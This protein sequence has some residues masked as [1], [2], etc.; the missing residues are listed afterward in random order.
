MPPADHHKI[1]FQPISIG[2]KT[3]RNR[4]YNV[5]HGTA[6][7]VLRPATW[8]SYRGVRAEGGWAAVSTEFS[9]V[10]PS[11]DEFP[12]HSSDIWDEEDARRHR[13]MVESVHAHGALAGIELHHGG[14]H[15]MRRIS[16]EPALSP[17]GLAS[18]LAPPAGPP[19]T[20]KAMTRDDIERIEEA[21]VKAAVRARD[22]GY[23]IVDVLAGY[24]YLF[25]Q[26]LSPFHN[27]R[28]DMYGGSLENRARF[29][30]ETLS[31]IR[32][33]IGAD[34]TIATR[35]AI[36]TQGPWGHSL[37]DSVELVRMADSL[38]DLWD[39]NVG[40]V[41][42]WGTDI[43]PSRNIPEGRNLKLFERI[44]SATDKPIVGVS[45][46]SSPDLMAQAVRSGIIDIIGSAR[47]SIADPFF[48]RKVQEGRIE[49]IR[50][51]MGINQCISSL[52]R[53]NMICAQ[54]ATA[55]EEYRRGW[56]PERFD[57]L[58]HPDVSVLVVGAGPSGME[59]AIG[60]AKRGAEMV[61]LVDAA[62]HLGGH[63]RPVVGLPGLQEWGR[64]IDH[65]MIQIDKLPNL[66]FIPSA[67]MSAADVRNY[68]ATHVVV[69]TG[70][71]WLNTGTT[72]DTHGPLDGVMDGGDWVFTPEQLIV[73]GKRPAAGSHVTVYDAEGVYMGAALAQ[74][75]AD[76]GYRVSIVTPHGQIA[77]ECDLTLDGPAIR[78][79]LHRTGVNMHREVMLTAAHHGELVG[80]GEFEAPFSLETDALVLVTMRKPCDGLYQELS[81]DPQALADSGI[82]AV[83]CIG[84]ALS[85]RPIAEAMFDGHRLAREFES[86][87]PSIA[88]P[89]KRE[90]LALLAEG[91][92]EHSETG[93]H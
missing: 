79:K 36:E 13:L 7:G 43:S 81:G 62:E 80:V 29:W 34:C 33:A 70:A 64:F 30:L 11:S 26:F 1:L 89:Y 3:L 38:I 66:Q 53:G 17:S 85:P 52:D 48:P 20:P 57:S 28:T 18:E 47:Q 5:P 27:H 82:D 32:E 84:D 74:L 24:G 67:R 75:L 37:D 4:F 93:R 60:L 59:A 65:R 90:P 56:H 2:P 14:A 63:L 78:A 12:L 10:D 55:G 21:F 72:P 87:D 61:H 73:E 49:D 51:C 69:A 41:L 22:V 40:S 44:R 77:A 39:L 6:Y 45:R 86:P 25:A 91:R 71:H 23:D 68:G 8:A 19:G 46:W 42:D 54:N 16:R 35:L 31:R 9:A 76:E 58:T 15:A 92:I 50:E 83:Y 88:L